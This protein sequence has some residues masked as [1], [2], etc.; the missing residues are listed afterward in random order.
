MILQYHTAITLSVAV[1]D[2][3]SIGQQED[4]FGNAGLGRFDRSY[5]PL[6]Q[7]SSAIDA[8]NDAACPPT[9]QIGN[10][11]V[12]VAG[13]GTS[14]C[15]IGAIEYQPYYDGGENKLTLKD[16]YFDSLTPGATGSNRRRQTGHQR[17]QRPGAGLLAPGPA[18]GRPQRQSRPL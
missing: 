12:D 15:D 4:H 8:G 2:V 13:V 3:I 7:T 6:L 14:I 5:Y 10:P 17:W 16:W 11:R 1:P 9:D 18:G